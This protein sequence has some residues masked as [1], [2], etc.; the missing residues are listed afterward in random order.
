MNNVYENPPSDLFH[1]NP[2]QWLEGL[3]HFLFTKVIPL[4]L[5][6][7]GESRNQYARIL[8]SDEAMV[9]WVVVFTD[10]SV[11]RNG[12]SNYQ[13]Y[14]L[15]G[16]RILGA[17]FSNFVVSRH[18][19]ITEE[20]LTNINAT[21]MSKFKQKEQANNLGLNKWVRT[22]TDITVHTSE[23]LFESL[24]GGLY[25]IGDTLIGK[26][27]GYA[28]CSNL[29]TNLYYDLEI[30]FDE[31]LTQPITQIK[32]IF[33][34]LNWTNQ[35]DG[36]FKPTQLGDPKKIIDKSSL[37]G[38]RWELTLKLTNNA[39]DF[40]KSKQIWGPGSSPILASV[41]GGNKDKV[42]SDAFRK[43]L[44]KLKIDYGIDYKWAKEYADIKLKEES[45]RVAGERMR[46]DHI[47]RL[48][49][50]KNTKN[51]SRQF[52]QL[53]GISPEHRNVILLSV[54]SPFGT[55]LN[56]LKSFALGYYAEH[57]KQDAFNNIEYVQA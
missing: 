45:E 26:G 24:F 43:A 42:T 15:L 5:P 39:I 12:D 54:N 46:K 18:P 13:L 48:F 20:I 1:T 11:D 57:G 8:I 21:Y 23:D 56:D 3:R 25:K 38:K 32:E 35:F 37:S 47:L 49:F 7:A 36:K 51:E 14:E 41:S 28:L 33:E 16:D 50:T 52:L 29:I 2:K 22:N 40:L 19:G 31:I 6:D 4:V 9:I 53:V 34:K 27:N 17:A 55:L 30:N 10:P 44:E